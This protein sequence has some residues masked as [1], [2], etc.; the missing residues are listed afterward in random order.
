MSL[1]YLKIIGIDD[2]GTGFRFGGDDLDI[3]NKLLSGDGS[4]NYFLKMANI[5]YFA[6][7]NIL[8]ILRPNDTNYVSF[9]A[10]AET[11][12]HSILIP[13][14]GG[15]QY[16]TFND[17]AQVMKNKTMDFATGNAD[18]N[19]ATNIPTSALV[20][21]IITNAKLADNAVQIENMTDSSVGT[22]ELVNNAV[23]TGKI[24][25][26]AVTD[27]K[28]NDVAWSKV[29]GEPSFSLDSHDHDADYSTLA[30]NHNAAY[31]AL[32]HT[33]GA[34]DITS[35]T[36]AQA[37]LPDATEL[38]KGIV[39]FSDDNGTE[40]G[41]LKAI[42]DNDP[43]LTN[44]R[45]PNSHSH[46]VADIDDEGATEGHVI[47][48][49]S[50]NP[51]WAADATGGGGGITDV[52]NIGTQGE[53]LIKQITSG[54]VELYAIDNASSNVSVS[55]NTGTGT[56]DIDVA[57]A[58]TSGKGIV[59][60]SLADG[61]ESGGGRAVQDSDVRIVRDLYEEMKT[62]TQ[63]GEIDIQDARW[64]SGMF[65]NQ[66][67]AIGNSTGWTDDG[68]GLYRY[69]GTGTTANT[70]T[71]NHTTSNIFR[72]QFK[73]HIYFIH[74]ILSNTTNTGMFIGL[75]S[76]NTHAELSATAPL[77]NLSGIGLVVLTSQANYQ[78]ASNSGGA[79]ATL[80]NTGISKSTAIRS[81]EIKNPNDDG[82]WLVNLNNGEYIGTI[83]T[84]VPAQ[85]TDLFASWGLINTDTVD[86]YLYIFKILGKVTIL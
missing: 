16:M 6:G 84:T 36:I 37:R 40:S 25:D 45:D 73:P 22:N 71:G 24:N 17:L 33:H 56:I 70:K 31:S 32:G 14:M 10:E 53:S 49:V 48:I 34:G 81:F 1:N 46:T 38:V 29:T 67:V 57:D 55:T 18:K 20:N 76:S 68:D 61:S 66:P 77:A 64:G 26:L 2:P 9:N 4:L 54:D 69:Y 62:R 21:D 75:T 41:G 7:G 27:A 5:F 72:R 8:R 85:T 43:R 23:T 51:A 79:T 19:I 60:L 47:K 11:D 3:I 78:I 58:S 28:I 80:T 13:A 44:S 65:T 42:Q 63:V 83:T 50:G 82:N 39:E 59:E 86:R 52:S 15:D 74:K 12:D 30:H 35:G